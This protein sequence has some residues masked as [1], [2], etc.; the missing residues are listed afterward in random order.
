MK[1][2]PKVDKL[3]IKKN[4]GMK[5]THKVA[6]KKEISFVPKQYLKA[7]KIRTYVHLGLMAILVESVIFVFAFVM[8]SSL[9]IAT[10]EKDVLAIELESKSSRF[11][12]VNRVQAEL[13]SSKEQYNLWLDAYTMLEADSFITTSVL[14]NLISKVP[15]GVT[16]SQVNLD[17]DKS[18]ITIN[19]ISPTKQQ[20][21]NYVLVLQNMYGEMSTEFQLIETP[22]V[23]TM[24]NEVSYTLT[25]DMS[26]VAAKNTTTT[27]TITTGG[28]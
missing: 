23:I 6:H 21:L 5:P 17:G 13:R 27:D 20:I 19:G 24:Q 3:D 15:L 1:K 8:P 25:I 11:D 28:N 22:N 2:A 26:L 14:D 12:E 16:I 7:Q 4:Q 9:Q 10:M 18:T